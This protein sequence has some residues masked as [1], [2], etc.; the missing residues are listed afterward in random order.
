[1]PR[2]LLTVVKD[3]FFPTEY[4]LLRIRLHELQ[5]TMMKWREIQSENKVIP[6]KQSWET[7]PGQLFEPLILS[8]KDRYTTEVLL[9]GPWNCL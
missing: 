4:E 7:D 2:I 3:L 6:W 9:F 8:P 5:E 1:M